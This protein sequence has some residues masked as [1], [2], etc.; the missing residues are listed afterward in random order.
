MERTARR[1][2]SMGGE[3]AT[4]VATVTTMGSIPSERS[5]AAGS[6]VENA[7]CYYATPLEY[8]S[9]TGGTRKRRSGS[10]TVCRTL[11]VTML[12]SVR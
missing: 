10:P 1:M 4:S 3:S 6:S 5:G 11:Q 9:E 8:G 2:C 7:D 12:V